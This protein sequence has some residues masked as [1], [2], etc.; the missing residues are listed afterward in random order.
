M[1]TK[2][3]YGKTK[4]GD[5]TPCHAKDK[6]HC[7]YHVNGS[8]EEMTEEQ[9]MARTEAEM[10]R[11]NSS[12]SNALNSKTTSANHQRRSFKDRRKAPRNVKSALHKTIA[13]TMM[14]TSLMGLAAC[15]N[16]TAT[17]TS[18]QQETQIVQTIDTLNHSNVIELTKP[19]KGSGNWEVKADGKDIAIIEYKSG[20]LMSNDGFVLKDND[21]N[22]LSTATK[23]ANKAR[24]GVFDRLTTSDYKGKQ[25]G[26]IWNNTTLGN[27][28]KIM[29][30]DS[31]NDTDKTSSNEVK[32]LSTAKLDLGKSKSGTDWKIS[33]SGKTGKIE[34]KNADD[35]GHKS[36][37]ATTAIW[38]AANANGLSQQ[39]S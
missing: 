38:A 4:D 26:V 2:Q 31:M 23:G 10:E 29:A 36:V 11:R 3:F 22:V 13:C 14:A 33:S 27:K 17:T 39:K 30:A 7:P 6:N 19:A 12:A 5:Y 18:P 32:D 28:H 15:G 16:N 8:H 20:S 35:D 37:N 34:V 25:D 1:A 9:A 24:A 21:G